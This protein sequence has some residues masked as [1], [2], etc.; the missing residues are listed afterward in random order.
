MAGH[1]AHPPD[2]VRVLRLITRLN[3]GGPSI[4]AITL[5]DRL[6]ARGFRHAARPR[7]PRRRRRR[8]ALPA[9]VRP[10][11]RR[12]FRTL[13]RP[14]GAGRRRPRGRRASARC[15]AASSG[16]RSHTHGQGRHGRPGGGGDPQPDAPDDALRARVVHTYHGHVLDGY[17]SPVTTRCFTSAR[18]AAGAAHRR[19]RR[20]LAADQDRTARP[21]YR[22]GTRT[23][24]TASSRS[25]SIWR[26]C[27]PSTTTPAARPRARSWAFPPTRTSSPRSD[28]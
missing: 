2:P 1:P 23:R 21:T 17:F 11:R 16:D 25:A 4:Q 26:R 12:I 27:S 15:C 10:S 20:H 3:I 13:Q 18:T 8:H 28:G 7:P 5:S 22:I 14:G 19:D 24:S 6:T 9:A